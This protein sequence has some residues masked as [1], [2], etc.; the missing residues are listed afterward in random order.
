MGPEALTDA[1]L[2]AIVLRSGAQGVNVLDMAT[3][4]MRYYR[5]LGSLMNASY[6][7]LQQH[8]GVGAAKAA[9]ILAARELGRRYMMANPD[10]R[11]R[12]NTPDDVARLLLAELAYADQEHVKVVLIDARSQVIA[13]PTVYKGMLNHVEIRIG[14]LFKEAVRRNASAIIIA[15]NHPSGDPTP[16]PEDVSLTRRIVEAGKLL[17]IDVLDHL[18]LGRGAWVSLKEQGV[19]FPG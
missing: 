19:S 14:E 7:E 2:L 16:S 12:V 18:V 10:E 13:M 17:G 6:E 3:A 9:Q 4:L 11:T 15:H 1:E 5:D 8:H